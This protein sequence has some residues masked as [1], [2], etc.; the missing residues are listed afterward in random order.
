MKIPSDNQ[1]PAPGYFTL[2]GRGLRLRCPACG[3]G[4]IFRGWLRM[5]ER[6][7]GCGRRFNRAP[8]YLLGSIYFNYGV[9]ALFVVVIYFS[10]YFSGTFSGRQLLWMLTAFSLLFPLWFFRYARALWIAFDERWDPWPNDEERR[11]LN[12]DASG[13]DGL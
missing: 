1:A 5:N 4:K 7:P 11:Q 10:F 13:T 6:C 12:R 3:A 2:L 9:T 8:G